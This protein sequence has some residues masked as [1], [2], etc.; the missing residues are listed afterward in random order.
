MEEVIDII[1]QSGDMKQLQREWGKRHLNVI[2]F[3]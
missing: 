3:T 1:T 2:D